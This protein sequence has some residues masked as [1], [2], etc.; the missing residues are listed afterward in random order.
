[1]QLP[2]NLARAPPQKGRRGG[3]FSACQ[4]FSNLRAKEEKV[5][6]P[7][8]R[9]TVFGEVLTEVLEERGLS[10]TSATVRR[11]AQ[12]AGL[13]EQKLINRMARAGADGPGPLDGLAEALDLSEEAMSPIDGSSYSIQCL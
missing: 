9:N 5:E 1:M 2:G 12:D 7:E 8:M 4:H 13:A 3:L 6:H 11:L 10:V